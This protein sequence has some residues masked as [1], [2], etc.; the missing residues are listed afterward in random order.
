MKYRQPIFVV[1]RE[2][3]LHW[4]R[5]LIENS[6]DKDATSL[7]W[8]NVNNIQNL[9]DAVNVLKRYP[10]DTIDMSRLAACIRSFNTCKM[11]ACANRS[12]DRLWV[13]IKS[14]RQVYEN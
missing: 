4:I 14:E 10:N 7:S 1:Q 2:K 11:P 5:H 8:G 9:I 12:L 6:S 13:L 3:V